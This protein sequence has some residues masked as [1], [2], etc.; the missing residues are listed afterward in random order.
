MHSIRIIGFHFCNLKSTISNQVLLQSE[1]PFLR[2]PRALRSKRF[3]AIYNLQSTIYP[4]Q[5]ATRSMTHLLFDPRQRFP[6]PIIPDLDHQHYHQHNRSHR[7]G[8][9]K[10][11]VPVREW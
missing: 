10:R 6:L 4:L 1:I 7:N 2:V 11:D 5:F 9:R 3:S 8:E